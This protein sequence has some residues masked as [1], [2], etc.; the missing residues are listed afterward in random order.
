M[1]KKLAIIVGIIIII[2][3]LRS[4]F[5][6]K[7]YK[8]SME[9]ERELRAMQQQNPSINVLSPT[10]IV[11]NHQQKTDTIKQIAIRKSNIWDNLTAVKYTNNNSESYTPFFDDRQK[12]F[13]NKEIMIEGYLIP[14]EVA[15]EGTYF[16]LS[17]YPY[18]SCFFC[19]GA[20]IQ[21]L[22]EVES[23]EPVIYTDNLLTIKGLFSLNKSN[24]GAFFYKLVQ[25]EV[26]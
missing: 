1:L 21:T 22:I 12:Q 8:S 25:A 17:L 6:Y 7:N 26:L 11:K 2:L 24:N 13:D 19:G 3:V 15:K 14:T 20:G 9:V 5:S 16:L 4:Y 18:K 10:D 23:K